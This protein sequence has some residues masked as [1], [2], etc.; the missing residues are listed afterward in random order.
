MSATLDTRLIAERLYREGIC[1]S[2]LDER[3]LLI[4]ERYMGD[5]YCGN[6]LKRRLSN[7]ELNFAQLNSHADNA[8]THSLSAVKSVII[9]FRRLTDNWQ[10]QGLLRDFAFSFS[11]EECNF[12]RSS[13]LSASEAINIQTR[14]LSENL[15]LLGECAAQIR[16]CSASS[17]EI[18]HESRLAT[19]AAMLDRDR[20]NALE[21]QSTSL[22]AHASAKECERTSADYLGMARQCTAAISVINK[23][24]IEVLSALRM[25]NER[26]VAVNLLSPVR[27]ATEI[28]N[29]IL[30]LEG[31][32][33]DLRK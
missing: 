9:I 13:F 32:N 7:V 15:M 23:T 5:R 14:T 21:C 12:M 1:T 26:T 10:R 28:G 25:D 17:T 30:A 2:A 33:F 29:A 27:A 20:D 6:D 31:L 18:Y 19:F 22:L 8:R 16:A 24:L 4:V 11:D 3:S